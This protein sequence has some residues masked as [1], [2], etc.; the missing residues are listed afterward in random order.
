[1]KKNITLSF[2]LL[3]S[4]FFYSQCNG[5]YENEIFSSVNVNTVNYSDVYNDYRHEMDIYTPDGDNENNRPV[6]IYTHGGSF[7]AGDKGAVDCVDFCTSMAKR[8]YVAISANY[9]LNQSPVNFIL[10]TEEQYRTVLKSVSDIKAAIRYLRKE[11]SNSNQIGIDPDAIYVGGYSAGAVLAIHLAYIDQISDLPTSPFNAQNI[12]SDIGGT[13]EGDGGNN[14]FS[15]EVNGIFSFGGGINNL[16]WI[17][18]NDEPI[19]SVHGTNDLL[20]NYNCAPGLG[21]SSVL[22]LCG[23]GEMHPRADSV[24]LYNQLLTYQGE[25]HGWC[26]S[27]DNNPLFLQAT[28]FVTDFL[29]TLLPCNPNSVSYIEKNSLKAKIYPNP[30]YGTIN[31]ISDEL[32]NNIRVFNYLGAEVY[33]KLTRSKKIQVNSLDTG[34]HLILLEGQNNKKRI[35]KISVH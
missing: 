15:S 18:V 33:S 14:G 20:V 22:N 23:A 35:H 28:Q 7:Y 29:F 2:F 8:G 25:D 30:S 26:Q 27:G 17:N 34:V 6:V 24:G 12:V 19:V 11:Y 21:L 10:S 31:I 1:M 32:I 16:D 3:I 13:L 5:R 4:Y 9:R